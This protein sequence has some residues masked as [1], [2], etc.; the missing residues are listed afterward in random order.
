MTGVDD[1]GNR[2]VDAVLRQFPDHVPGTRPIHSRGVGARGHFRP[3]AEAAAYCLAGHFADRTPVTVRFSNLSGVASAPDFEP[4]ARGL[5]VKFHLP[6]DTETD[7]VAITVPVV[8]FR[9]VDDFLSFSAAAVPAPVRRPSL[10]A[11]LVDKLALRSSPP[12][13]EGA[14]SAEP[15]VF[16]YGVTHPAAAPA[17]VALAHAGVPES[18]ARAAYHAVHAFLLSGGDGY[19]RA[20]R[21]HWDPA[22]GV[23]PATGA[24]LVLGEDYLRAEL[25][26]RLDSGPVEFALRMQVADAGDDTSDPSRAW[27]WRRLLVEMGRLVLTEQLDPEVTE[28]LRFDPTR[29]VDGIAASDDEILK[30]RGPAYRVSQERRAGGGCP[31]GS[32]DA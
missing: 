6:G 2:L 29:L 23:R 25:G 10:L 1:L 12:A 31:L 32:P 4:Q 14:T 17:L 27:P 20:V 13:P 3:S 24:D 11:S 7:L 21:F 16:H 15:G 28:Q 19:E 22:A 30:A 18:Y 9:T 8:P 5:S 26:D